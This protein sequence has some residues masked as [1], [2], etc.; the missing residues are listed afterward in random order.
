[1]ARRSVLTQSKKKKAQRLAQEGKIAEAR[2]AYGK[3]C[4]VDPKDFEAWVNF[5]AMSGQ[6]G[7]YQDAEYAFNQA[8]E[9]RP[10]EPAV[11]YNLA[12]LCELKQDLF[13]AEQHYLT[14]LKLKPKA[15]DGA[16]HLALLYLNLARFD[17]SEQYCRQVL[18]QQPENAIAHNCLANVLQERGAFDEAQQHYQISLEQG[19]DKGEIYGNLGNLFH[20]KGDFE[21]SKVW[22][23]K[24]LQ[25][26]PNSAATLSSLA[27]LYFRFGHFSEAREYFD[28][29]LK[30]EPHNP[31]I[32]WNR[33]LLL[34][35][36]GEFK[37]GWLDY[38]ARLTAQGT[39]HQMGRRVFDKPRWNG[40]PIKDKTLLLHAE[41]GLGDT[42][43]FCRYL[44]EIK[45]QVGHIVLECQPALRS[46]LQGLDGVD[47]LVTDVESVEFDYYL[48]LLSLPGVCD[49][50][51]DNIPARD[52]Y[53]QADSTKVAAWQSRLTGS[54]KKVG[55]VWAGNPDNLSDKRRSLVLSQLADL[56]AIP[57]ITLYSLQKGEPAQQLLDYPQVVDLA[58]ELNDFSD[59]AAVIANL[60]LVISV[61]TA[62][63]H[64]A[65]ALGKPVWN[66]IY[67]PSDWRWFLGREDTPWYPSM[68]L[69]RQTSVND[70]LPVVSSLRDALAEFAAGK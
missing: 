21:A 30:I 52:A 17:E 45:E 64:L 18:A 42:I 7:V 32:R 49:T 14:Y 54:G 13:A 25:A 29:A 70:W 53:L 16:L 59:T 36:Q 63:A 62:V 35:Q 61:D 38:E 3:I 22:Y 5:G 19:A 20:A 24:S 33:A 26:S 34:L 65:G 60:D 69:F 46:L 15:V 58:G 37:Q 51:F 4:Q 48:P 40:K 68:R 55:L 66:L 8:Y 56:L 50:S 11:S 31:G 47:E 9:L 39:V 2:E 1:M 57:G 67:F 27:F 41:Q 28:K 44:A 43:Q 23:E 6:L 10:D 12:R